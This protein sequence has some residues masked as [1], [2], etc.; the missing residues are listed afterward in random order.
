MTT[1]A[2]HLTAIVATVAVTGY[3]LALLVQIAMQLAA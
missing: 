1:N 2:N 3:G